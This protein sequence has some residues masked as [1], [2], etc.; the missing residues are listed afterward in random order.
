MQGQFLIPSHERLAAIVKRT[1]RFLDYLHDSS[2][3]DGAQKMPVPEASIPYRKG[4][5]AYEWWEWERAM[6]PSAAPFAGPPIGTA[7]GG[8]LDWKSLHFAL[9]DL[10][11]LRKQLIT[12]WG[13]SPIVGSKSV[14]FGCEANGKPGSGAKALFI[15]AEKDSSSDP[16]RHVHLEKPLDWPPA[17]PLEWWQQSRYALK[18]IKE[19]M[20]SHDGA[21][22]TEASAAAS[23]LEE[24]QVEPSTL[25]RSDGMSTNFTQGRALVA[26]IADYAHVSKLPGNVLDD[27]RDVA[28]LLRSCDYCGYPAANVELLLDGE[29][30]AEGIRKALGRLAQAAAEG[31]TVVFFFSGHGG[32]IE[33][34]PDAG[35]YLIPFDC[36]PSNLSGTSLSGSEIADLL[37]AIKAKRLVVLLDACHSAGAADVKALE[38]A[39]GIKA[40][41]AEK[42]YNALAHGVGRVMMASSRPSE[43]SFVLP[44]MRNS[45]FTHHLLDA[46]RGAAPTHGDGLVRVF[47]VFHYVS[48]K[49]PAQRADQHPIFKAHEMENNF[50][51]ALRLG[52]KQ[53]APLTDKPDVTKRPTTLSGKAKLA[54]SKNLV[55]RWN[56]LATY[57]DIPL[58]DQATFQKGHEPR[59]IIDW[60]EQRGRLSELRDAFNY[61]GWDDLIEELD[62][63]P[64]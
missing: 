19:V 27:A 39:P 55:T 32:R 52:G 56:D 34:G 11:V 31:E 28:A 17:V 58:A 33:T 53:G 13:L 8:W 26:G 20:E 59:Q 24:L 16:A 4:N 63:H 30:S 50:P 14:R 18:S 21:I 36:D 45:L 12:H 54:L 38:L 25:H 47:D 57:F 62:R 37:K 43:V 61:L 64:R 7:A 46:L 3:I 41:L 51:L 42:T 23:K 1:E 44:G 10:H 40:G 49:V 5:A 60:L 22:E 2:L 35:E 48:D 15:H 29:A 6:N 9:V